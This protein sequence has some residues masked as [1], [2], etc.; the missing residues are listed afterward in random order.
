[1]DLL[2]VRCPSEDG[3]CVERPHDVVTTSR[4]AVHRKRVGKGSLT[5]AEYG[6]QVERCARAPITRSAVEDRKMVIVIIWIV[7]LLDLEEALG[8]AARSTEMCSDS[9]VVS[10]GICP[11]PKAAKSQGGVVDPTD[12]RP[13]ATRVGRDERRVDPP[14]RKSDRNADRPCGSECDRSANPGRHSV[15]RAPPLAQAFFDWTTRALGRGGSL[16]I[17]GRDDRSRKQYEECD[18]EPS[19]SA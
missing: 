10:S 12:L 19:E 8:S 5:A 3:R 1:M 4:S 14:N 16:S 15:A 7:G 11:I 18:G 13:A 17:R 2:D 6:P 9:A